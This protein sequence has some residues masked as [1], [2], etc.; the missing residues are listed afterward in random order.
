[1][2]AYPPLVGYLSLGVWLLLFSLGSTGCH[3]SKTEYP[4]GQIAV[5]RACLGAKDELPS[6]LQT[7]VGQF[8]VFRD[9]ELPDDKFLMESLEKLPLELARELGI[10]PPQKGVK[11]YI[12]SDGT[13]FR[14][15]LEATYPGLPK[16]RAYFFAK[17]RAAGLGEEM[18]VLTLRSDRLLQDLRHEVTHAILHCAF[19]AVP[20]WIDE[21]I[22]EYFE[23]EPNCL[24]LNRAHLADIQKDWVGG[25]IPNLNRLESLTSVGQMGGEEYRESWAWVYWLIRLHP[26]GKDMIQ[27][28][29]AEKPRTSKSLGIAQVLGSHQNDFEFQMMEM[30][31]K[32]G[33]SKP[34][35]FHRNGAG[36]P[37]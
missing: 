22:A 33:I 19:G 23:N 1:M 16:R 9:E 11:V 12:F 20:L 24:G 36:S 7:R 31:S 30:M 28:Y 17:K 10:P 29:L 2:K 4:D 34:D 25:R 35:H 13:T 27:A 18:Q 14:N 8:L 15:F 3:F 26:G 37:P 32:V 6:L 21:G 5:V